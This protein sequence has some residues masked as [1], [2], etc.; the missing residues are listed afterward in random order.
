MQQKAIKKELAGDMRDL[1]RQLH[2]NEMEIKMAQATL[3]KKIK[4]GE[5]K[6]MTRVYAKNVQSLQKNHEKLLANKQKFTGVGMGIDNM[7][8]NQKM[9]ENMGKVNN[10]M[11]KANNMVDIGAIT[12]TSADLQ[13][14]MAKMDIM[15]DMMGDAF[16]GMDDDED[17]DEGV[18]DLLDS[19]KDKQAAKN[20]VK[21]TR[22][23]ATAQ[24]DD[25]VDAELKKM[26]ADMGL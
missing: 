26:M 3:Q 24:Q 1:D 21:G 18:D 4:A 22:L 15:D 2:K 5:P 23:Q 11:T 7:F 14:N 6:A 13:K 17:Y 16:G 8:T 9:A 19:I 10:V 25:A 12:K 20:P